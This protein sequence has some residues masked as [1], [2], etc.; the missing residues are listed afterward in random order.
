MLGDVKG[1]SAAGRPNGLCYMWCG[2]CSGLQKGG[3]VPSTIVDNSH[4]NRP[5]F[6]ADGITEKEIGQFFAK[7]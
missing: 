7:Q 2:P 3:P 6:R 4:V 5:S 1:R